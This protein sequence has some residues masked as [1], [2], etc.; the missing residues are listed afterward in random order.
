MCGVSEGHNAPAA[1]VAVGG[2]EAGGVVNVVVGRRDTRAGGP[3]RNRGHKGLSRWGERVE[4]CAHVEEV[5]ALR[6]VRAVCALAAHI[7]PMCSS[8]LMQPTSAKHTPQ[9]PPARAQFDL[10]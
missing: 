7:A 6:G 8:G 10:R 1:A 4:M 9:R 2:R 5:W 3:F